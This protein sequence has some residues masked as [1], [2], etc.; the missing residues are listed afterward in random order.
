M[1]A[2]SAL[3]ES[4]PR[5]TPKPRRPTTLG[6]VSPTDFPNLQRASTPGHLLLTARMT[7]LAKDSIANVSQVLTLDRRGLEDRA[8][9]ICSAQLQ[10]VS[11]LDVVLGGRPTPDPRDC[12]FRPTQGLRICSA[13]WPHASGNSSR[14]WHRGRSVAPDDRVIP[15]AFR[16]ARPDSGLVPAMQLEPDSPLPPL[17]DPAICPIRPRHSDDR[18]RRR[19]HS[20]RSK[21]SA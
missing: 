11:G 13:S 14:R 4:C 17:E 5:H 7:G 15:L 20:S 16:P 9:S 3:C 21:R 6:S 10:L 18:S 8:G 2:R 19:W 1:R 12:S